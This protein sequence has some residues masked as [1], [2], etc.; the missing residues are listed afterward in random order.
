MP[1][2]TLSF[3]LILETAAEDGWAFPVPSWCAMEH[4]VAAQA[5]AHVRLSNNEQAWLLLGGGLLAHTIDA[6]APSDS[7]TSTQAARAR[8]RQALTAARWVILHGGWLWIA[9]ETPTTSTVVV[10]PYWWESPSGWGAPWVWERFVAD[11]SNMLDLNYVG[12]L[13]ADEAFAL[14]RWHEQAFVEWKGGRLS[15]HDRQH[16][17]R[18]RKVLNHTRWV[19]M[20]WAEWE[21][22]L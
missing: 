17:R 3:F 22:G 4:L 14:D 9:A 18:F 16:I 12:L 21:S 11:P 8:M 19:V 7:D 20:Y 6:A 13:T 1:A 2:R 10:E 5:I 15:A